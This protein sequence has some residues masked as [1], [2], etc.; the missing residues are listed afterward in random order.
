MLPKVMD[1][2]G[3]Y[4]DKALGAN[5]VDVDGNVFIDYAGGIGTMNVGH[6]HPE[7]IK[8]IEKQIKQ[9]VHPCFMVAPYDVYTN[10]AKRL[11]DLVPITENVKPYF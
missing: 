8:A 5:L 10:L 11:S 1:Q 2:F 6:S 3:V 9:F 7:I 4:I